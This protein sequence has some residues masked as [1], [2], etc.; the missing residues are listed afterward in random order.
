MVYLG[1]KLVIQISFTSRTVLSGLLGEKDRF[2][3]GSG[4]NGFPAVYGKNG[5]TTVRGW[6][7]T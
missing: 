3:A 6:G 1:P 7:C 2:A 4:K 5:I